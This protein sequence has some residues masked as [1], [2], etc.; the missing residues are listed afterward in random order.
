MVFYEVYRPSAWS[1]IVNLHQLYGAETLFIFQKDEDIFQKN[2]V[3]PK[4]IF[5]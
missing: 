5:L 4:L 3:L 2:K 1:V